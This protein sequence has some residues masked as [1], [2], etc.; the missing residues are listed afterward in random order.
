MLKKGSIMNEALE[1]LDK[2]IDREWM[3]VSWV[4][5]QAKFAPVFKRDYGICSSAVYDGVRQGRY[6]TK[7]ERV[8]FRGPMTRM[9][10]KKQ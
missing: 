5:S 8:G 1:V 10:R 7:S 9:I 6:E 4:I 2:L 3:P